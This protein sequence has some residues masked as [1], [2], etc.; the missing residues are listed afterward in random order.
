MIKIPSFVLLFQNFEPYFIPAFL[1]EGIWK[2]ADSEDSYQV[3]WMSKLIWVF[4]GLA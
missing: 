3:G 2:P 4:A 1:M